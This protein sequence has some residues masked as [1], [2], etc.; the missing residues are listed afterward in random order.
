MNNTRPIKCI[1]VIDNIPNGHGGF[2]SVIKGGINQN[3][4]QI[5]LTSQPGGKINSK[6]VIYTYKDPHTPLAYKQTPIGWKA[7]PHAAPIHH[8]NSI[9][10]SQQHPLSYHQSH[11]PYYPW[12]NLHKKK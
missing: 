5:R 11:K 9:P 1:Q 4:T 2:A 3:S 12:P 7:Q 6:V 8:P 10:G